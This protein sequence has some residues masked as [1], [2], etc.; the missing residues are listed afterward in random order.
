[1]TERDGNGI[2]IGNSG[3][4]GVFGK[5]STFIQKTR[6]P[7]GKES[8]EYSGEGV[9]CHKCGKQFGKLENLEAHHLSKHAGIILNL[10][11]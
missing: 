7:S 9:T 11:Y 6:H 3:H 1:M 8:E 10:N 4:L 5:N 2:G